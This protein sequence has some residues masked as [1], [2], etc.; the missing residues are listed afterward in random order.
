ME[1]KKITIIGGYGRTGEQEQVSEVSFKMGDVVSI[2][3]PTGSGKTALVHDIELFANVNTPSRRRLLINDSAL[4]DEFGNE[5]SE[6]PVALITQHTNFLSDL[7]VYRFLELHAKIRKTNI[8]SLVVEET[9]EFANQLTGEPVIRESA[10]TELSGG[11]TRALLVADAVIIGSSPI[12]LLDEIENAGINRT[13]A[14]ELLKHYEK[15]FVFVTHD[16]R[17]ALLSD[18]RIVMKNGAMQKLIVTSEEEKQ[19]AEEIKKLDDLLLDF[20]ARIRVGEC[21]TKEE[22]HK[23][24]LSLGYLG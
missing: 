13:K 24:L 7:P 3:G 15:I 8:G 1:I 18:F 20:R 11:Q 14:I 17:I 22:L 23:K 12:I 5:P 6:N 19:V 10:M 21:I 4:P 9:L 16:P 2:V